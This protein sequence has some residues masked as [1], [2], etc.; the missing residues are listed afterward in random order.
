[1]ILEI[2]NEDKLEWE[3][4]KEHLKQDKL[5]GYIK[6]WRDAML[7]HMWARWQFKLA[8]RSEFVKITDSIS[9]NNKDEKQFETAKY[10][11][12]DLFFDVATQRIL[13]IRNETDVEKVVDSKM[14]GFNDKEV[15]RQKIV[16]VF[17]SLSGTKEANRVKN[18][19]V[20]LS[21]IT[22][23]TKKQADEI[24]LLNM[25]TGKCRV[26]RRLGS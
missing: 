20:V 10:E 25:I 12:V 2:K 8:I 21:D 23:S 19:F 15:S 1:M 6:Q 9:P 26:C 13:G 18:T 3:L 11:L 22:K 16:A 14:S 24:M 5:W 7:D 17:D 4:L